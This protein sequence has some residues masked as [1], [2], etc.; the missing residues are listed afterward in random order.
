[1]KWTTCLYTPMTIKSLSAR[2]PMDSVK[3]FKGLSG[4]KRINMKHTILCVQ[5]PRKRSEKKK[6]HNSQPKDSKCWSENG[7][8]NGENPMVSKRKSNPAVIS[9]MK[10]AQTAYVLVEDLEVKEIQKRIEIA[11][12]GAM[13]EKHGSYI[14]FKY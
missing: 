4:I 12:M 2:Q 10:G 1:M 6:I 3:M 7:E 14:F 8:K 13:R 9:I 5:E 11:T